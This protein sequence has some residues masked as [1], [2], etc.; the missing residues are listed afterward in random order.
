MST[1]SSFSNDNAQAVQA[2]RPQGQT[3]PPPRQDAPNNFEIK[4]TYTP[5]NGAQAENTTYSNFGRSQVANQASNVSTM[6]ASAIEDT[7]ADNLEDVTDDVVENGT[8]TDTNVESNDTTTDTEVESNTSTNTGTGID[9]SNFVTRYDELY[10]QGSNG[11]NVW[12]SATAGSTGNA[13]MYSSTLLT[14]QAELESFKDSI[15]NNIA[16]QNKSLEIFQ[17]MYD[18][19]EISAEDNDFLYNNNK[20]MYG[21]AASHL[22]S[23]QSSNPN[24]GNNSDANID[25]EM[26]VTPNADVDPNTDT[27]TEAENNQNDTSTTG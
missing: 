13:A 23:Q 20:T 27:N 22:L 7:S 14:T 24:A 3:P 21:F 16:T 10:T 15:I 12:D 19:K 18:G 8:D 25:T 6:S 17:N 26:T 9:V 2:N 5:S 1:I 11:V 4:D